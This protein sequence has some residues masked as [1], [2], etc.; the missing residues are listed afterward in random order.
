MDE[1]KEEPKVKPEGESASEESSPAPAAASPGS[2]GGVSE[3]APEAAPAQPEPAPLTPPLA[4]EST[5]PPPPLAAAVDAAV[6]EPCADEVYAVREHPWVVRFCHWLNAVSLFVLTASGLR[7]FRAFPSFGPKLPQKNLVDIPKALTLG[8]WLGGALRWHFTFMWIFV[9]AGI[10][11]LAYE[12]L[13]GHYRTVLF[14][15]RDVRGVWPMVRHYFLF[16]PEPPATEQ[17][18]PLQKLAY[19]LT[20]MLGVVSVLTGLVMYKPIQ[21]SWLAWPMGGFHLARV[22]HFLA[23]CGFLAFIPG[24]LI[25]VI[26]HGW[27]NFASMLTGW[28]RDPE[29]PAPPS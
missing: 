1:P 18:N 26:L 13:S 2:P 21:F 15:A 7:I 20:V 29:Y 16:G 27:N 28:K 14:M 17:Y 12:L 8:G 19:T 9:G 5:E 23:M 25:M 11:Y 10:A 4:R 3:G 6:A 22:W 24:H